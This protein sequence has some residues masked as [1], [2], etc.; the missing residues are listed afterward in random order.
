[1]IKKIKPVVIKTPELFKYVVILHA[2]VIKLHIYV[3]V[4]CKQKVQIAKNAVNMQE[5][6]VKNVGY[7]KPL[8]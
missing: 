6:N 3:E 7:I 8:E 4:H 2:K 1:M 5:P